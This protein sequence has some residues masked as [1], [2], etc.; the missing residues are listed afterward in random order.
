MKIKLIHRAGNAK[1]RLSFETK[2]PSPSP[3]TKTNFTAHILP[4]PFRCVNI[5][6][7]EM[8]NSIHEEHEGH[9]KSAGTL[10]FFV[11]FVDEPEKLAKIRV[12]RG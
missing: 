5:H 3:E 1:H 12:I 4:L 10:W 9:E 8:K 11:P 2:K 7:V 6:D